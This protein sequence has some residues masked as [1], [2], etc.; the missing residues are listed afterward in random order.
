M[1]SRIGIELGRQHLRAVRVDGWLRPTVRVAQ[2]EWEGDGLDDA[3]DR[4]ER[5]L[6]GARHV[7]LALDMP[8]VF[9]KEIALPALPAAEKIGILALEPERY[10]PVRGEEMLLAAR[11]DDHLVFAAR[12]SVVAEA[13]AA[14][15]RLGPVDR[16]EPAPHALARALDRLGVRSGTVARA[17]NPRGTLLV[18]LD[19]GKVA[20]VRWLRGGLD[21]A[22]RVLDAGDSAGPVFATVENGKDAKGARADGAGA[23][24]AASAFPGAKQLPAPSGM[25]ESFLI[26]YGAA[27]GAD[28]PFDETLAPPDLERRVMGR[29]RRRAAAAVAMLIG[30]AMFAV[31]SAERA[32]ERVAA[33]LADRA[34]SLS[35]V[36][37]SAFE[38]HAE[39]EA[40]DRREIA[41]AALASGRTDPLAVL[42]ALGQRMPADSWLRSIRAAGSEWQVDGY[43]RDAALLVP[44]L[45]AAPEF[46]NVRFLTATTTERVGARSH[47]SFSIAFRLAGKP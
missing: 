26:A 23:G 7:T 19:R 33:A 41:V 12:E 24:I 46:E 20:A 5:E 15:G 11:S 44:T 40:L 39:R 34:D 27:L 30:A 35:L 43:A 14:A 4:V 21:A 13:L 6:G 31:L 17:G 25:A 3:I 36:A 8:L 47:E 29:R 1:S 9:A 18:R 22:A 38:L 16:V 10:F 42:A 28:A 2:F 45:E 37:E 32:A